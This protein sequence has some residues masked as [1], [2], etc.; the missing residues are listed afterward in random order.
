[1]SLTAIFNKVNTGAGIRCRPDSQV[2]QL[3]ALTCKSSAAFGIDSP[4][5]PR[6]CFITSVVGG[7]VLA[8]KFGRGIVLVVCDGSCHWVKA[9]LKPIVGHKTVKLICFWVGHDVSIWLVVA[10]RCLCGQDSEAQKTHFNGFA[11]CPNLFWLG[12][13]DF[14][15]TPI[16][17]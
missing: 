8:L 10:R 16:C 4:K 1:M 14:F 13:H 6:R 2:S 12:D 3:A 15:L 11:N 7:G 17:T 5:T 9:A